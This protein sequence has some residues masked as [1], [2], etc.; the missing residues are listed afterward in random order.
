MEE[1]AKKYPD[2]IAVDEIGKLCTFEDLYKKSRA[3]AS[4]ILKMN[5]KKQNIAVMLPKG[6]NAMCAFF[7]ILYSGKTYVPLDYNDADT[8][9]F[10]IIAAVDCDLVITDENNIS[11]FKDAGINAVLYS[12][13]EKCEID[14]DAIY[15]ALETVCDLDSAY[16]MHTSGS[17]GVPKGVVV[18]HR[19]IIDFTNWAVKL[20]KLDETSVIGLQSPFHF[21]AS[22]FDI[23]ACIATGAKLALLPDVLVKFP[24]KI[25]EFIEEK[26]VTCIFWV[27]GILADIANSGALEKYEMPSLKMFTFVGEVMST[28]QFNMWYN[29]NKNRTY[30]NLYGPTEATVACTA[31]KIK[32]ALQ[33]SEPIPIGRAGANKR[34]LII[35]EEG[36]EANVGETGEICILG[37]CLAFGYYG[38][39]EETNN[40]FVQNPANMAYREMMYKTGD[41]GYVSESGDI[42]FSGRRDSQVKIHG[43]RVELGD[44]ENAACCIDGIEKAST[45]LKDEKITLFLQTQKS[46]NKR[47]F[48][49]LLKE[50]VPKYMLP[51]AVVCLNQFPLNKNGKTD[52]KRLISENY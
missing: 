35:N 45:V 21:D 31:Y 43:I 3:A 13:T 2:N 25:P 12:E 18:S 11:K 30:I 20:M 5:I 4:A 19:A 16:I 42:I 52:K 29:K 23:Y 50:H 14:D 48:N 26:K 36:R 34:I 10:T 47:Q 33:D 28:R 15:N 8:R 24:A 38:R 6:A 9:L 51:D 1:T 32:K 22:V 39:K 49:L 41:F 40:V 17:T 7:A 46:F 27:P 44:I 37:S